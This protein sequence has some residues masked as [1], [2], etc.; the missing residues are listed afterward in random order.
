MSA[1]WGP[2]RMPSR[3][4]T[5]TTGIATR[6]PTMV[7]I[8][9]A[10]AATATITRNDVA[11]T[12]I[13][14]CPPCSRCEESTPSGGRVYSRS[15]GLTKP[16]SRAP[17]ASRS[18]QLPPNPRVARA[19]VGYL[20]AR[21]ASLGPA[22]AR[23]SARRSIAGLCPTSIT[24]GTLSLTRCR[25]ASRPAADASYSSDSIRTSGDPPN[26]GATPSSVWRA[27][28]AEAQ[29]TSAGWIPRPPRYVAIAF[30]ALRPR[31]DS[32]RSWSGRAES[33]WL[34]FAWRNK[35]RR[36]MAM[37]PA[38]MGEPD[39]SRDRAKT[40]WILLAP[41]SFK[42]TLSAP[43]VA[44]AL[45]A[46]FEAAGFAVDP[47]PLADGGEG[48]AESLLGTLGGRRVE[49]EVHAPLGRSIGSSFVLLR[50][51]RTAVMET[52]SAS[53]FGLLAPFE[54]DAEA[55]STLGTG[56][57]IVAASRRS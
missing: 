8:S 51:G 41:D 23:S 2:T 52:A 20:S 17:S 15:R 6:G 25:R 48:T 54:R 4:S 33:L 11:S 50:D 22:A 42:G 45:A 26:P 10:T 16:T 19:P 30:E 9:P 12:P 55:A 35:R 43:Q 28:V 44:A 14:G 7:T 36:F 34:D 3:I 47:C 27:R 18:L 32:G 29:R 31:E 40:K 53:G 39:R 1:T 37:M 24:E 38:T 13:T 56:E 5:T 46:P 49:A 57:L 21:S